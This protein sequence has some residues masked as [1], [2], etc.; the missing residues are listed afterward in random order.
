MGRKQRAYWICQIGGWS[1]YIASNLFFFSLNNVI[2]LRD[3]ISYALWLPIGVGLTHGYRFLIKRLNILKLPYTAQIPII[4]VSC[5]ILSALFFFFNLVVAGSLDLVGYDK[6]TLVAYMRTIL[7]VSIMFIL[8]SI[9]YFGFQ[10]FEN[11]KRAEI[12]NLKLEA[13]AREVELN[14]LKSQLNPHFMFNSMNSIRALVDENPAKAKQAVTQL[15]NILRSTLMIHKNRLMSLDEEL[16]LVKDYLELEHI[17]YEERLCYS[18]DID[19]ASRRCL[20][21][22]MLLQTLVENGIKHG[23]SKYPEGGHIHIY[24][25]YQHQILCIR[26]YNSGQIGSELPETGFGLINTRQRLSLLFGHR[27]TFK[28]SN[29]D[30]RTVLSEIIINT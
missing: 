27:A 8:W 4:L 6:L 21:P 26:I 5:F 30:E 22:P 11:Y 18:F 7:D 12:Q 9:V 3:L 29:S 10:Y 16:A 19:P 25:S 2:N 1:F 28:V 13:N 24:T 20:V 15:S 23:I 14:T 17:R